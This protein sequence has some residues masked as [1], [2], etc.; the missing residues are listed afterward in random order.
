MSDKRDL[1]A[2]RGEHRHAAGIARGIE[3]KFVRRWNF[4]MDC[5]LLFG[6]S[7]PAVSRECRENYQADQQRGQTSSQRLAEGWRPLHGFSRAGFDDPAQIHRN[8]MRRLKPFGRIF[9]EACAD[10][11]AER[12]WSERLNGSN[13]FRIFFQNG[14]EHAELRLALE[15]APASNH[16]VENA[17]ET[18]QVT[19]RVGFRSL[20]TFRG[21]ILKSSDDGPLLGER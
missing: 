19:A 8:V 10:Y 6:G 4:N 20:Q 2:L 18:E 3:R 5:H 7:G 21:H 16:F 13:G 14:G 12:G 1:V 9:G 17:S 15:G 11:A